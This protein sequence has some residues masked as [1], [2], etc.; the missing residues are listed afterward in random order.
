MAVYLAVTYGAA[1]SFPPHARVNNKKSVAK[2]LWY[3]VNII[4]RDVR[5]EEENNND[6]TDIKR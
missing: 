3:D 1:F 6:T 5:Y 2:P 4:V